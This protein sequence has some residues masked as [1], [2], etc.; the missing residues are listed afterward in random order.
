MLNRVKP[1]ESE[2]SKSV[3]YQYI[4]QHLSSS[5]NSQ[6]C[7]TYIVCP[8]THTVCQTAFHLTVCDL[9]QINK[10][11]GSF[12]YLRGNKFCGHNSCD[13]NWLS[14]C[15]FLPS[16]AQL[17]L[18]QTPQIKLNPES[19]PY[20]RHQSQVFRLHTL[21]VQRGCK[22]KVLTSLTWFQKIIVMAHNIQGNTLLIF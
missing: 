18:S 15:L 22:S 19:S 8:D 12:W 4:G 11:K 20:F 21:N 17:C 14:H 16:I 6:L 1:K 9:F 10:S 5:I 13:T 2:Y 3:H 7:S